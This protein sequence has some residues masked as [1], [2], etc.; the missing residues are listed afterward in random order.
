MSQ[1]LMPCRTT[2]IIGSLGTIWTI[3]AFSNSPGTE[4]GDLAGH[5]FT[6]PEGLVQCE[7]LLVIGILPTTYGKQPS[8]GVV[9]WPSTRPKCHSRWCTRRQWHIPMA[10]RRGNRGGGNWLTKWDKLKNPMI[11]SYTDAPEE[12]DLWTA[13]QLFPLDDD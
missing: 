1:K 11:L 13:W 4:P 2:L 3:L 5:R 7:S 9:F 6:S 12:S 10:V 8:R